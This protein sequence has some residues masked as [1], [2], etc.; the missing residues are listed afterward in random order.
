VLL[1]DF[2]QGMGGVGAALN[3]AQSQPHPA[4]NERHT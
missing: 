1:P 2:P 3:D 4:E